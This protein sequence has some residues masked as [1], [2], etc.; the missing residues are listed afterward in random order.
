MRRGP[1]FTT[2]LSDARD[3]YYLWERTGTTGQVVPVRSRA[4]ALLGA[5]V[6]TQIAAFAC[7]DVAWQE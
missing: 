3:R 5:S 6:A 2:G 4:V 1:D 7:V